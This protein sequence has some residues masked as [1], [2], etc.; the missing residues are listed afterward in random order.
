MCALGVTRDTP[1][2][3]LTVRMLF[4]YNREHPGCSRKPGW[5]VRWKATEV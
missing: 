4:T 1:D 3:N 2:V 5:P